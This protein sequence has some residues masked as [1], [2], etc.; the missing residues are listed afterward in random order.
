[1]K[2]IEA[3]KQIISELLNV[4]HNYVIHKLGF[5]NEKPK[6][7]EESLLI[8]AIGLIDRLSS[9][10]DDKSKRIIVTLS[11]IIWTYRNIEWDGLKDI[12]ILILCRI[13]Y[14]PS[15][16][17]VDDGYDNQKHSSLNSLIVE[18]SISA[19]QLKYEVDVQGQSYLLTSFQKNVWE[20]IDK[21]KLLGISAPTSAG[22]SYIIL[23]KSINIL[24]TKPGTII[25][26]V[27]TISLVTQVSTDFRNLFKKYGLN[28]YEILN[29]YNGKD[30]NIKK[31]FVLTQEKA[32]AAFSQNDSPFENV[33]MLVVD[34]IQNVERVANEADQRAKILYDALIDYRLSCNADHVIISGPRIKDID[35]LGAEIFGE[36][37]EK[38][39]IKSSP[40]VN[41]TYSITQENKQ[42]YLKQ[43][44]DIQDNPKS[45][46]ITNDDMVKGY[47]GVLYKDKEYEFISK[48]VQNLGINSKNIVF[49]PTSKK[50]REI[51][52]ELAVRTSE[53][54]TSELN[55]LIKYL[56]DTVHTNYELCK[57]LRKGVAYH[58]G[59]LPHHVRRVIE[60]AITSKLINN[61]VCTTTL[62]QGV[63][64]PAQNVIIRNP[65][66]FLR[67]TEDAP[68]LTHY[69]IANLRGRAGRL[70]KDFIG[71]TYILDEGS[72]YNENA[73]N[74][75]L[76]E[77]VSKELHP[78]YSDIYDQN[79]DQI[80]NS[81]LS[82]ET[83]SGANDESSFLLT[84]IRQNILKYGEKA[85]DRFKIVGINLENDEFDV[86]SKQMKMLKIP[87]ELCFKNRYWDPLHLNTLY[88]SKDEFEIP[89]S[90][91]EK[92]IANKLYKLIAYYLEKHPYY[93]K[94]YFNISGL[95]DSGSGLYKSKYLFMICTL[96][97]KWLKENPLK[98]I[99]DS[100]YYDSSDKIE[101]A[102]EI[103]QN[104][105]AY[106]LPTL[107]KPIFDIKSNDNI[108]LRFIETG[109]YMPVTR[110]LI[111]LNVPREV[112]IAVSQE[113]F[114]KIEVDENTMRS[115]VI[116]RLKKL[117]PGFDYWT[118][119]QLESII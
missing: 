70:L 8:K 34:E 30:K 6:V 85:L 77:D 69:E 41:I 80:C 94:R 33:R 16:I 87:K 28:E 10:E 99:L 9:E 36:D 5:S 13:G 22:K 114:H 40:V 46:L 43:Y 86:T 73:E 4:E 45:I 44:C 98:K 83:P 57:T 37:S 7:L 108:F 118:Q 47:G 15:A 56:E 92:G 90:A 25:Y 67:R 91:N 88:V 97:E 11:A 78:G 21:H 89:T 113:Y 50:A 18:M 71:R 119:V 55:S 20:K 3:D 35:R 63:N 53:N 109:A 104:K 62:M 79:K 54:S 76:F 31:V 24:K 82:G 65:Y 117:F 84:Y 14:A 66:L 38:E 72:F 75:I 32:V 1:M 23:L 115:T 81:L 110:E 12:L 61:V 52:V 112:A 102:I 42:Y 27:P 95:Y 116:P 107:L 64:L 74:E 58:H 100:N 26:I 49:S 101:D 51:A 68:K 96:A 111:E 17:M 59:K 106:G 19:H 103:L 29:T 105:I 93:Y 60:K 39:E 48:I 2:I